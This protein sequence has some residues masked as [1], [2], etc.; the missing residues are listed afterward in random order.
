MSDNIILVQEII[1]TMVCKTGPKGHVALK[2]DLDKVYDRLEWSFIQETL[3]FFQIPPS[4]IKLIMNMISLT[5]FHIMW[6]GS[7][8]PAIILSRGELYLLICL[9]LC[10][11]CLSILLEEAIQDKIVHPVTFKG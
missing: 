1:R 9:F 4:L 11:E 2:L 3:E 6:N 5:H 8:L 7:P 10:L